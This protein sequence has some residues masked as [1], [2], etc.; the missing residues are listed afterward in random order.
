MRERSLFVT[1]RMMFTGQIYDGK[2]FFADKIATM[3]REAIVSNF[4]T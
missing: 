1:G 4:R 3:R 2:S